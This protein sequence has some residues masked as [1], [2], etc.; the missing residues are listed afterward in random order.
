MAEINVSLKSAGTINTELKRGGIINTTITK[1]GARGL[2]GLPGADGNPGSPGEDGEE[3]L[4]R[5]SDGWVQTKYESQEVWTNLYEIPD[6]VPDEAYT[7]L[8][9]SDKILGN[10]PLGQSG[11]FIDGVMAFMY[12]T[13]VGRTVSGNITIVIPGSADWPEGD[14]FFPIAVIGV[15]ATDLPYPPR[16]YPVVAEIAP[17]QVGDFGLFNVNWQEGEEFF[18]EGFSVG[19]VITDFGGQLQN[20]GI[21]TF[22]HAGNNTQTQLTNLVYDGNY[23]GLQNRDVV[24]YARFE[25]EALYALG[26]EP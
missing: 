20:G 13:R 23:V 19:T 11:G 2:Q 17:P 3:L 22:F 18:G 15:K 24:I 14:P 10:V 26:E 4:I 25:Y 8:D 21:F 9:L 5:V 1:T 6:G 7:T 16:V 12:H